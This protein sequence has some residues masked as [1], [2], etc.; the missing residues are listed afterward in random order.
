MPLDIISR[1]YQHVPDVGEDR[2]AGDPN[3]TGETGQGN[4]T[5]AQ[6]NALGA[7]SNRTSLRY[8]DIDAYFCRDCRYVF[9]VTCP[10][11][12][13]KSKPIHGCSTS[14]VI[15][16]VRGSNEYDWKEGMAW[17]VATCRKCDFGFKV[18]VR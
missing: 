16:S 13:I 17:V 7:Y 8:R 9:G 6:K 5:T 15:F 4:F 1:K 3:A 18:L 11:C 2:Y 10:K 12:G 14:E